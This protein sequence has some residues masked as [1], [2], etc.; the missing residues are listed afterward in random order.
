[1]ENPHR[2][3]SKAEMSQPEDGGDGSVQHA[4][5][6]DQSFEGSQQDKINNQ[7]YEIGEYPAAN[8]SGHM[9]DATPPMVDTFLIAQ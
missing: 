7:S 9:G 8:V 2:E 4:S 5:V 6:V 3:E 1:M